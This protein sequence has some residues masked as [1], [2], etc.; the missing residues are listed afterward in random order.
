MVPAAGDKGRQPPAAH[1][2]E[3]PADGG[4]PTVE[5][6]PEDLETGATGPDERREVDDG[7][8]SGEA[9]APDPLAE[10]ER[11][12]DEFRELAQRKQAELENVRKRATRDVGVAG[13]RATARLV[14]D[15]LPAIDNLERALA[16]TEAADE[17]GLAHGVRLVHAELVGTLERNGVTGFEP[18]GEVFDPTVHEA[19]TT[20]AEEDTEP[21][22]VLDVAQRGYRLGDT[23]IR[24]A[25]VVVSA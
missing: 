13:R 20:R 6:D 24:P 22:L 4:T 25:R 1:T 10:A 7:E 21:G 12:R 3:G 16:S 11:D 8:D 17:D 18:A 9:P 5:V 15:L 23:V 2:D 14:G 19:L